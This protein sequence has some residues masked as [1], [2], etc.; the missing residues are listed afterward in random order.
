MTQL[1][2]PV[3]GGT[4]A[5]I[6][7]HQQPVADKQLAQTLLMPVLVRYRRFTYTC[8]ALVNPIYI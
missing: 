2:G 4:C 6:G 8:N 5:V 3:P 1:P 7:T